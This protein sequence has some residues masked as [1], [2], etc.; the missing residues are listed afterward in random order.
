MSQRVAFHGDNVLKRLG[1][2]NHPETLIRRTD[3]LIA[4][5][6]PTPRV[7]LGD[8]PDI[9]V[10]D[11]IAGDSGLAVL[12]AEGRAVLAELTS[13]LRQL[14]QVDLTDLPEFDPLLRI[15]PRLGASTPGWID[16]WIG[17]NLPPP[18]RGVP[19]H[20]DFH[21]G[22]LIRD[23]AGKVW[24]LDLDDLASGP[25][26]ADIGNF[27]AH[28]ATRPETAAGLPLASFER[29]MS[30]ILAIWPDSDP[31]LVRAYGRL[32]LLRR[33]L[34]LAERGEPKVLEALRQV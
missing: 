19:I 13:P 27:A 29:W 32:A 6:I 20:G 33:S 10:F 16:T 21:A 30:D 34:K 15:R 17:D 24:I 8:A 26:E 12:V 25:A 23:T 4:N 9:V 31:A 11:R 1:D 3:A 14:H 18:A 28:L 2:G 5:G 22:Q 7:R